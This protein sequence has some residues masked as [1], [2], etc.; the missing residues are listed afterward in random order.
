MRRKTK[1]QRILDYENE[2]DEEE[3][4]KPDC[5]SVRRT[6]FKCLIQQRLFGIVNGM[7]FIPKESFV[8]CQPDCPTERC[9]ETEKNVSCQRESR[10]KYI[11]RCRFS[12][13]RH[14]GLGFYLKC[15]F[16]VYL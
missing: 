13:V 2:E 3:E 6:R 14:E 8:S 9:T 15:G 12:E 7:C 16:D 5:F 11:I 10:R 4:Q 1:A